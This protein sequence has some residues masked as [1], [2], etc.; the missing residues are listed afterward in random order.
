MAEQAC[1]SGGDR[2]VG[3]CCGK[4]CRLHLRRRPVVKQQQ[5]HRQRLQ[6]LVQRCMAQLDR[7]PNLI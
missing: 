3:R 6:W 1:L 4:S 5:E 7:Q 2:T